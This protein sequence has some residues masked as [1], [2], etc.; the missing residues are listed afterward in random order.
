[1][2][3]PLESAPP[4]P[5]PRAHADPPRSTARSTGVVR[6]HSEPW[7]YVYVAGIKQRH[8][9]PVELRLPAGTHR[10]RL[11]NPEAGLERVVTTTIR[12]GQTR[13]MSIPLEAR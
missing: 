10:I 3:K 11:H 8:E 12:A 4:A 6:L 13:V 1:V 2:V 7:A 5:A 9:T